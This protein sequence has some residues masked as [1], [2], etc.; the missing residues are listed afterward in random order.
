MELSTSSLSESFRGEAS[1]HPQRGP[2]APPETLDANVQ[3]VIQIF[4]ALMR[5]F[6]QINAIKLWGKKVVKPITL[7]GLTTQCVKEFLA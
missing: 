2:H 1:P 7:R 4:G 6:C 5:K 3:Y